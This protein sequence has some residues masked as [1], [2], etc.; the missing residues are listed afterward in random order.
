[1]CVRVCFVFFKFPQQEKKQPGLFTAIETYVT[2]C[3]EIWNMFM[4][5]LCFFL[6]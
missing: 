1:M 2:Q 3:Q 5:E 6:F 4:L